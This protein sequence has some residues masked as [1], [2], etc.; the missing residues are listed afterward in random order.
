MKKENIRFVI[1][2]SVVLV[3][4]ETFFIF[5]QQNRVSETETISMPSVDYWLMFAEIKKERRYIEEAGAHY[6]IPVF[7]PELLNLSGK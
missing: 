4:A 7:T 2:M 5:Y 6:R 3:I 1:C